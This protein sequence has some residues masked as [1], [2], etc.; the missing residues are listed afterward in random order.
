GTYFP[1]KTWK[2]N[3]VAVARFYNENKDKAIEYAQNL[4]SGIHETLLSVVKDEDTPLTSPFIEKSVVRWK[5]RFDLE[6][7]G[8]AG[9]PKFPMPVNLD[10]LLYYAKIKN[11]LQVQNYVKLTLLKIAF[12]GIYDHAGGGFARYSTDE[13]WKVP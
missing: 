1:K 6:N 9:Y 10:F 7:G 13:K 2:D 8:S 5:T 12:G 3:M 11:D 4:Q